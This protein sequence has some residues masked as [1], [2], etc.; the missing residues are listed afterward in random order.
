MV[1][2]EEMI[3]PVKD[4]LLLACVK[5]RWHPTALEEA[6]LIV[7]EHE[8]DWDDFCAQVSK[9]G[10][11]PLVYHTLRDD[12]TILP[13]WVKEKLQAKYYRSA[14][15]NTLLYQELGEILHAFNEARVPVILLKGAALAKEVYGNISLR[16]MADI[17]FLLREEH[18]SRAQE[19]LAQQGYAVLDGVQP[20]LRH[21]TFSKRDGA[22]PVHIE[23]HWHIISSP[24]YRRSIP[25]EWLWQDPI[26]LT[27][28][29]A[30]ALRLS[31]QAAIFHACLHMLDHIGIRGSLLYWL[32]DIVEISHRHDIDWAAL[33]DTAAQFKI[34]LPVRA[35]LQETRELL[36]LPISDHFLQ[37][38][39]ARRVG[40]LERKA[41]QFCLSPTRSSASKTF[42]DFFA[43][44]GLKA[45]FRFLFSRIFPDRDYMIARYSIRD[46]WLVPLYYPYMIGRAVLDSLRAVAQSHRR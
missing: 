34:I 38:M 41:Y 42:F 6:R 1:V 3:D 14:V 17:D 21:G 19:L 45:K 5:G 13:P 12:G 44:E 31:P 28:G 16:P 33:A 37:R 23:L 35:I 32:C 30:S 24:Y 11:A 29:D 10:V 8:V 25:E 27:V 39:L 22:R 7:R 40:F 15:D 20:H 18:M 26:E 2:K 46:P 43:V 4:K 36:D 9:H